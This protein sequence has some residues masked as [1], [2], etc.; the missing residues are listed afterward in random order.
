VASALFVVLFA[1]AWLRVHN[2][3]GGY[4]IA[5]FLQD[6][7][8]INHG[9][10]PFSTLRGL[11]LLGDHASPIFYPVAWLTRL[12]SPV[13]VLLALQSAALALGVVPLWAICRRLAGLG[14]GASGAVL[15]AYA[16]YPAL[17]N[18]NLADFHPEVLA[19]PA[20]LGAVL[21]GLTRRWPAFSACVG[22]ALLCKED[23]A[24]VVAALGLFLFVQGIRRPGL[25]T[26][27]AGLAVLLFDVRILLPHFAGGSYAQLSLLS[28]YG[29]TFTD[30]ALHMVTHPGEVLGDL[31]TR[32]NLDFAIAVLA[33]VVFLPL[34][35]PRFLVPALPMQV[36]YLVSSRAT[37]HLI[38]HQYTVAI[39]PFVFVAVA[40]ALGR[41]SRRPDR[42]ILVALVAA[43]LL[44]NASL[45]LGGLGHSPWHAWKRDAVDRARLAAVRLLPERAAV[46]A[47]DRIWPLVA[48]RPRFYEFPAPFSGLPQLREGESVTDWI[49]IDTTDPPW[50]AARDRALQDVVARLRF[51]KVF[52][53]DGVSVYRRAVSPG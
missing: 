50:D 17:H 28:H 53:R 13:V 35:A 2:L 24:V 30:V 38:I 19:V 18:L 4:D 22:V 3:A 46:S 40:M 52:D 10:A 51:G 33:P 1:L 43:S 42:S 37:A 23:L 14:P 12:G 5:Y 31:L 39:L 26:A 47:T 45:S 36:L 11:H 49:V 44:F 16:L 48:A 41:R 21:F 34:G 9:Q 6:A 20:L 8:L 29:T 32:Q 25:I 15:A 27:G 7:W